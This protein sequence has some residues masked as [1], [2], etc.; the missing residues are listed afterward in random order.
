MTKL[1]TLLAASA[2]AGAL[3]LAGCG[4]SEEEPQIEDAQP[5]TQAEDTESAD[6]AGGDDAAA[7][8][9]GG[10]LEA[11]QAAIDLAEKEIGGKAIEIDFDD[12]KTWELTVLKGSEEHEVEI[13]AE[14]T[15][16][17]KK[18]KDDDEAER[19]DVDALKKAKTSL[20]DALKKAIDEQAGT[21]DEAD[22]E[23][24]GEPTWSVEIYPEGKTDSV[25]VY[26]SAMNGEIVDEPEDD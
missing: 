2:A 18:E 9:K 20:K 4:N 8:E 12:E 1:S 5:T 21:I 7:N 11:A 17:V 14:G 25:D 23:S 22:L 10:S 15:E 19:E 3:A 16:I 6:D 26:V 24:D 13:N